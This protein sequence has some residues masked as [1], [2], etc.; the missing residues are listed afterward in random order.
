MKALRPFDNAALTRALVGFDRAFDAFSVNSGNYPP[1]NIVSLD[2]NKYAIEVAV[3]GFARDDIKIAVDQNQLVITG[4][5]P[6]TDT[7]KQ[8]LHRGIAARDFEKS[9]VLAEHIVVQDAVVQDGMLTINL[10][11]VV[12]EELKPRLIQIR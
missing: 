12:P 2:E 3:A 9:F 6:K 1:H 4:T 11:R 8:Y 10:E 5:S 7:E